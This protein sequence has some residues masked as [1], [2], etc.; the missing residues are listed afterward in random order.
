MGIRNDSPVEM[1]SIDVERIRS[2]PTFYAGQ[3]SRDRYELAN[4]ITLFVAI[5][6][7]VIHCLPWSFLFSS[8]T[9]NYYGYGFRLG[10]TGNKGSG[11]LLFYIVGSLHFLSYPIGRMAYL[12]ARFMKFA[13]A[14]N[15]FR[16][17]PVESL[18]TIP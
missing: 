4:I 2:V 16:S 5:P 18:E 8:A 13:F 14:L 3:P 11:N 1:F 12:V 6:F 17:L 15:S 7:G 9:E 10:K